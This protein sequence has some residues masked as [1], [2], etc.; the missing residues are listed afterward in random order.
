MIWL[1]EAALA[2]VVAQSTSISEVNRVLTTNKP[3]GGSQAVM[4]V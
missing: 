2:K 3:A 4:R 1:Q